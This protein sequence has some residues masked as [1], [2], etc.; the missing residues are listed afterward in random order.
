MSCRLLLS[1]GGTG[2]HIF[3]AVALANELKSQHDC[4]ILFTAGMLSKNPY[5]P[6]EEFAFKDVSCSSKL[7][8]GAY[9]NSK[10][11]I[12]SIRIIND[13]KPDAVVG[14]GSYYTLPTLAAATLLRVPILLHEANSIPGRINRFF[15]PFAKKTWVSFSEAKN[16]LTGLVELCKMPLRAEL[17][18]GLISKE[19][20]SSYFNLDA[21]LPT[22]LIFGGSQGAKR[23]NHLFSESLLNQLQNIQI[24]HF[25]GSAIDEE[26]FSNRYR[27]RGIRH[28]VKSFEKRMDLAWIAADMAIT[29]AGASSLAEQWEFEVPGILIPYPE[30]TDN[31]QD[32]NANDLVNAGLCY[33]LREIEIRESVFLEM[34]QRLICNQEAMRARF[35]E[36]KKS[37][38]QLD[39]SQHI[40]DW[41]KLCKN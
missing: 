20:A 37:D 28:Y 9:L 7:L 23:I 26:L 1:A 17:K 34:V 22:L 35:I 30:A 24:M 14:F 11:V 39:L 10:G 27:A 19:E 5:F 25:T 31:H 6:R 12:E 41:I 38:T 16:K 13:Y 3:P 4:S 2:G 21:R 18:K 8:K 32:F 15:S 36:S 33:K 40:M 29:R